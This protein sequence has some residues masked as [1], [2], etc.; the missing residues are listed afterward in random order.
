MKTVE[1]V[2]SHV[3][4][5]HPTTLLLQTVS[6][7]LVRPRTLNTLINVI[8]F[9]YRHNS[10]L[11]DRNRSI[12]PLPR[13]PFPTL[14]S[15][16]ITYTLPP[17]LHHSFRLCTVSLASVYSI[18]PSGSPPFPAAERPDGHLNFSRN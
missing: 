2:L 11:S 13:R 12:L 18:R 7:F 14:S 15:H 10:Q 1:S 17:L 4:S 6:F 3:H 5:D 9:L 8:W 16:R